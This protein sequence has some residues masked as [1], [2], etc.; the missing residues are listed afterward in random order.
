MNRTGYPDTNEDVALGPMKEGTT[1]KCAIFEDLQVSRKGTV[2]D[3][4]VDDF[5][6]QSGGD[7]NVRGF[8]ECSREEE[9]LLFFFFATNPNYG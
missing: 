1:N 4:I 9:N 6:C 2:I 3:D 7:L 8:H 5:L